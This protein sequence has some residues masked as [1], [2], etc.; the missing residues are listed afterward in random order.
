MSHTRPS[1]SDPLSRL[2]QELTSYVG[3]ETISARKQSDQSLRNRLLDIIRDID[4]ELET[5]PG[6]EGQANR[7]R[8][9]REFENTRRKLTLISASLEDPEYEDE[10]FFRDA[11]LPASRLQDLYHHEWI[12]LN[13]LR[14]LSAEIHNSKTEPSPDSG[15]DTFIQIENLIDGFNQSL[16][17]REALIISNTIVE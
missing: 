2:Q 12:L 1:T 13:H 7:Q 6:V 4:T 3:Y 16:F 10:A 11:T 5:I 14:L 15:E 9:Q 17:E 8:W